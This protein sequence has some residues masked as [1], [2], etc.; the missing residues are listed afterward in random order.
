MIRPYLLALA[1]A[2][3]LMACRDTKNTTAPYESGTPSDPAVNSPGPTDTLHRNPAH[4]DLRKKQIDR[5]KKNLDTLK[6]VTA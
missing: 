4:R 5:P 2:L 1:M 3:I 6:P